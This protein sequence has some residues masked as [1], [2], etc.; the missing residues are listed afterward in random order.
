MSVMRDNDREI[1][2]NVWL[3]VERFG[4]KV[5]LYEGCDRRICDVMEQGYKSLMKKVSTLVKEIGEVM[6]AV[7]KKQEEQ[8]IP[9]IIINTDHFLS[10]T[11]SHQKLQLIAIPH[12]SSHTLYNSLSKLN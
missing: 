9:I 5:K 1:S 12:L 2:R 7:I 6:F 8:Q 11:T 3:E 4:Q 10:A